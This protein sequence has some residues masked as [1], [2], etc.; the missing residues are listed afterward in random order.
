MPCFNRVSTMATD[1]KSTKKTKIPFPHIK[2]ST[3][4]SVLIRL[5]QGKH[6][7]FVPVWEVKLEGKLCLFMFHQIDESDD[8]GLHGSIETNSKRTKSQ[9]PDL[10]FYCC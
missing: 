7:S 5:I 8:H 10:E 1:L 3:A 9:A 2:C 6:L 4:Y